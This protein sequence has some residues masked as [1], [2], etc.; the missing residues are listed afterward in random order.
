MK[1]NEKKFPFI[2]FHFLFRIEAFQPVVSEKN[3]KIRPRAPLASRV[4]RAG[5]WTH[6]S[7][8][9]NRSS[10]GELHFVIAEDNT[11]AF[12]AYQDIVAGMP[13]RLTDFEPI[14]CFVAGVGPSLLT[15]TA[16]ALGGRCSP[17][18]VSPGSRGAGGNLS[19]RGDRPC[20]IPK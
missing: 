10:A 12:R 16:N 17:A 3:K 8:G 7:S 1:G 15:M 13:G 19:S 5:S 18:L 14:A 11:I 4:V 2:C 6:S 20:I 9:F